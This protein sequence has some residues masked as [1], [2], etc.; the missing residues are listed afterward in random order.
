MSCLLYG[1]GPLVRHEKRDRLIVAGSVG[2]P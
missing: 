1:L 2:L